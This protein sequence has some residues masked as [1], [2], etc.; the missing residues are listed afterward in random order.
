MTESA[1][2]SNR[3]PAVDL[4][5]FDVSL[6]VVATEVEV[7]LPSFA[8]MIDGFRRVFH[9]SNLKA[10][11]IVVDDGIGGAFYDALVS[12]NRSVPNFRVIRFRRTFGESTSLRIASERARGEFIITN[13]WYVQVKPEAAL[14]AIK[15]LRDGADFV[16]AVRTP[17]VDSFVA[18][19]QSWGFNTLTKLLTKV[20]FRDLN[21]SFRGYRKYVLDA[22]HFHGDLF[23][24]VPVLAHGQGFRVEE[25]EVVHVAEK[26]PSTFLNFSLYVRRFL[27]VFSLF[28]LTKFIKKPLRFFG[29]TGFGLF[30]LGVA[31]AAMLLF[32][33]FFGAGTAFDGSRGRGVV[34]RPE[35]I[36]AVLL[37]VLGPILLS[38]GLIGEIIIFTHGRGLTDYHVDT[39][40]GGKDEDERERDDTDAA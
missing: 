36:I 6:I 14:D 10:E 23:R 27:D 30:F 13:T 26:G 34:D 17:R 3:A 5:E 18:R 15:A 9:E 21:C 40:L 12:L 25:I 11:F 37:M 4:H 24:F 20:S 19:L 1:A 28:F 31:L 22:I 35:T 2:A 32:Q 38:I 7:D 33:K 16:A 39:I 29:L 8:E